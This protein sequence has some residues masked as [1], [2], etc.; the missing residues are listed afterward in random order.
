LKIT[1]QTINIHPRRPF[2]IARDNKTEYTSVI[3][4]IESHG[5]T[6][7]GEAIVGAPYRD[8]S[9]NIIAELT[10]HLSILEDLPD[11]DSAN[12]Y[13]Y[14]GEVLPGS[15]AA[16]SALDMALWDRLAK[17]AGVSVKQ[18]VDAP[19]PTVK[20]S[21]TLGF[22]DPEKHPQR[23]QAAAGYPH[24]KVKMDSKSAVEF[25]DMLLA[26]SDIVWR[27]DGCRGWNLNVAQKMLPKLNRLNI[28]LIEQPFAEGN[29]DD[30][31]K[32]RNF[33]SVPIIADEDCR[34]IEDI[35]VLADYYDGINLQLSKCGG[36]TPVLEMT[37]EANKYNL[38]ILLGCTIE[39]SIACSAAA[40]IA[41]YADYLDLDGPLLLRDDPYEGVINDFGKLRFPDRPGLGIILADV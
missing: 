3:V 35:P 12:W 14:L 15:A 16:R 40:Q 41:G 24:L 21:Y 39:T 26:E 17:V 2:A 11:D 38:K 22:G 34:A 30:V 31:A 7:I 20:S 6:G 28:D 37:S 19:E 5:E 32:L 1:W 4:N 13:P 18:L 10:D 29:Y 25:L 9:E 33:C 8:S 36:I 23:M 27:F